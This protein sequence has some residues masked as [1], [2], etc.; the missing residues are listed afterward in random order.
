MA[1]LTPHPERER[2]FDYKKFK[3]EFKSYAYFVLN[4]VWGLIRTVIYVHSVP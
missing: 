1:E 3:G 2:G 4:W